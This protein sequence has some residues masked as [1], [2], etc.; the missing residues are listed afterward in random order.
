VRFDRHQGT[1]PR[2]APTSLNMPLAFA[3]LTILLLT[4]MI[5]FSCFDLVERRVASWAFRNKA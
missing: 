2:F 3:S 5:L 1:Q 4:D